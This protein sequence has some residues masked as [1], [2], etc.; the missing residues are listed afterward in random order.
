MMTID[1]FFPHPSVLGSL[2]F[3][4]NPENRNR[5]EG[6]GEHENTRP[7]TDMTDDM[8]DKNDR[9]HDRRNDR[10]NDRRNAR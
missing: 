1:L 4:K 3:N 9:R 2:D 7:Q 10:S 5:K 6:T 8:T